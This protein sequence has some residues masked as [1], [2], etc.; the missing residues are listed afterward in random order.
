MDCN[1]PGSSV[2]GILQARILE[3]VAMPSAR[4]SSQARDWTLISY[5]SCLGTWVLYH[6]RHLGVPLCLHYFSVNRF[7]STTFLGSIYI[8]INIQYLFFSFGLTSLCITDCRFGH[9]TIVFMAVKCK[10]LE[11]S[12]PQSTETLRAGLTISRWSWCM[13]K[14]ETY[15]LTCLTIPLWLDIQGFPVSYY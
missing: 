5:I 7:I 9:L 2:H 12:F 10:I 1:Q 13:P 4:G 8:C 11:P 14:F 15:C 3:W 6:Y